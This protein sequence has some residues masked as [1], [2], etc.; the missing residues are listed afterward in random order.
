MELCAGKSENYASGKENLTN[1]NSEQEK[2]KKDKNWKEI[3]ETMKALNRNESDKDNLG[4]NK[5]GK[6]QTWAIILWKRA[7]PW[8]EQSEN[9]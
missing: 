7:T 8:K 6:E 4:K 2:Y 1:A 9:G 3:T 5:S